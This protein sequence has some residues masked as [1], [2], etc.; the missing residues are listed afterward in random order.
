MAAFMKINSSVSAYFTLFESDFV[1]ITPGNYSWVET[2]NSKAPLFIVAFGTVLI[3]YKIFDPDKET[4]K[5]AMLK[6]WLVYCVSSMQ[7]YLF[8]TELRVENNKSSSTFCDKS[9]DAVL[10]AISNLWSNIQIVRTC[11][12][13][14]ISP[15][16][17]VLQ[18]DT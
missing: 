5:V 13:S 2:K 17:W 16:L 4:T 14:I 15:I 7:I 3:E 11:I 9:S 8:S 1:N 18:Q 10:L 12:S 6:L